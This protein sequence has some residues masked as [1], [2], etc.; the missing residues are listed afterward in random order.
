VVDSSALGS[1]S[2]TAGKIATG[3]ISA[4]TQFAA[5]V[6]PRSAI[7]D[8]AIGPAQIAPGTTES[9]PNGSMEIPDAAGTLPAG[10]TKSG[11][12]AYSTAL[13]IGA[14]D[15]QYACQL[16]LA[17]GTHYIISPLVQWTKGQ[18]YGGRVRWLE[19]QQTTGAGLTITINARWYNAA[20][21]FISAT[22]LTR[23]ISAVAG[24]WRAQS[25]AWAGTSIPANTAFVAIQ[26]QAVTTSGTPYY[27]VD[28][29]ELTPTTR[30]IPFYLLEH[31]GISGGAVGSTQVAEAFGGG[32]L[33]INLGTNANWWKMLAGAGIDLTSVS[34]QLRATT[35]Q[36][37]TSLT[38]NSVKQTAGSSFP[39]SPTSGDG[40]DH[41]TL[42]RRGHHDGT[43][44]RSEPFTVAFEQYT[45][46]E[47][48]Y[49][50]TTEALAYGLPGDVA[51]YVLY[52]RVTRQVNGTH[53]A[54]AKWTINLRVLDSGGAS[55]TTIASVDSWSNTGGGW[56][57]LTA[58][59]SFTQPSVNN[60][61]LQIQVVPTGVPGSLEFHSYVRACEVL[62]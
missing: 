42:F 33:Q 11:T 19:Y 57:R 15:G 52:W 31:R 32:D 62:T 1:G 22:A 20:G 30:P 21:S 56:Q 34:G 51:L 53:S 38:I 55:T 17:T 16:G 9:P 18:S 41:S 58:V 44:W 3:G 28:A 8:A 5:G 48:P 35:A 61:W 14:G 50:G 7:I 40:H 4:S 60:G 27:G 37:D 13:S 2:V 39:G 46:T 24:S 43:R 12:V 25:A 45:S 29:C 26:F 47:P 6:V 10:W 36:L 23:E 49:T 54:L 59:T